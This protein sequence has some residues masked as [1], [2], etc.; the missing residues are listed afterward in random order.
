[1]INLVHVKEMKEE[2]DLICK[3]LSRITEEENGQLTEL[4]LEF[5]ATFDKLM[6]RKSGFQSLQLEAYSNGMKH[7][8]NKYVSNEEK[9]KLNRYL[10][11]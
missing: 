8:L 7:L 1:M 9:S 3:V 4:E 5:I 10:R 6:P 11:D 2:A